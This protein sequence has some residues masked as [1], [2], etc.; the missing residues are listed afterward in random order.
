MAR[1][2]F[3][4]ADQA[5]SDCTPASDGNKPLLATQTG[6]GETMTVSINAQV[7]NTLVFSMTMAAGDPGGG[8][9]LGAGSA[10][11]AQLDVSVMDA[12][13]SCKVEF[14]ALNAGCT[15][16][17]SAAM[18]EADFTG[19]GTKVANATWD[20]PVADRYQVRVLATNSNGHNGAAGTLTIRTNNTIAFLDIPDAPGPSTERHQTRQMR[21][22]WG[23]H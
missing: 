9:D 12:P 23:W 18:A 6:G 16:Q 10:F 17:G 15:S 13:I 1:R 20:P 22:A 5:D 21:T 11:Q 4:R 2:R 14:H 8:E 3:Q 7:M 19:M